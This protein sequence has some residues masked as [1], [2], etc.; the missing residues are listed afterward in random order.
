LRL[1]RPPLWMVLALI[2]IVV[3]TWVPL[4][5]VYHVRQQTSTQPRIHLIQDMDRQPRLGPQMPSSVFADRRAARP[6]I[7]GTIARGHL[8]D[9]DHYDRGYAVQHDPDT[10]ESSLVFFDGMPDQVQADDAFIERGR[11][12]YMAMCAA[13]HGV[14]GRDGGPVHQWMLISEQPGWTTPTRLDAPEVRE[15]PDGHLYNTIRQ[16][17]RNM[18]AHGSQINVRDRWAIVAYLRRLQAGDTE[19][20]IADRADEPSKNE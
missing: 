17:I 16:G 19:P 13:C 5:I 8:A 1:R 20:V 10:G 18:P 2:T 6:P 4:A 15:R 9:D 7:E 3:A 11:L 14:T 12:M